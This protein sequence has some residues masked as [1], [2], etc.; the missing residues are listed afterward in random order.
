MP[1]RDDLVRRKRE[2]SKVD[3]QHLG[4]E[5]LGKHERPG[6][7]PVREP[8]Q[9]R[10]VARSC[11][12][13]SEDRVPG[14]HVGDHRERP[15]RELPVKAREEQARP[16]R[17]GARSEAVDTAVRGQSALDGTVGE[18]DQLVDTGR[19]RPQ[20][21]D[22]RAENGVVRIDRLRREDQP[23]GRGAH[24][25]AASTASTS[26]RIRPAYSAGVETQEAESPAAAAPRRTASS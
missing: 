5:P 19:E 2:R 21:R 11:E 18:H 4:R 13:R 14:D 26:A 12:R 1:D 23:A 16:R 3:G 8:E 9:K 17:G 25:P 10:H 24:R 20:L 6:S 7:L 22:G 15:R